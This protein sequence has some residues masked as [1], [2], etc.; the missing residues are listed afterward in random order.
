MLVITLLDLE[1]AFGEV[2][3]NLIRASLQFHH[4]PKMFTEIISNIYSGSTVRIAVNDKWT[5]QIV[6]ERGVLQ[7]DPCSPLLFNIC[8]NTLMLTLSKPELRGLGYIWGSNNA[9]NTRS[10]LQFADDAVVISNSIKDSQALLN[11]FSAWCNWAHMIIRLDKC[12]SFSMLKSKGDY[13]Q[14]EPALFINNGLIPP[15]RLGETFKYLGK[16]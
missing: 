14:V 10:W 6:V 15:V 11:I 2:H 3:H 1:N 5:D 4:V 13:H 7:G 9:T 8:F 12:C 16:L